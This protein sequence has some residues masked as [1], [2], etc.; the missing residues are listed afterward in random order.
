MLSLTIHFSFYRPIQHAKMQGN[1]SL[2]KCG[3]IKYFVFQMLSL[4]PALAN[5]F[6]VQTIKLMIKTFYGSS[7]QC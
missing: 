3:E 4:V 5:Y 7:K 1:L 6:V 2:H